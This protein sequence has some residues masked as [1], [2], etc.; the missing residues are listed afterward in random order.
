MSIHAAGKKHKIPE[1]TLWHKL[2]GYQGIESKPGPRPLLTEQE[3]Q[4]LVNYIN[5]SCQRAHPVTKSN[6]I[7]AMNTILEEEVVQGIHRKR[8]PSFKG[9]VPKQK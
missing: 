6:I 3:E 5:N 4:V 2:S 1:A 7:N 9:T 8:P